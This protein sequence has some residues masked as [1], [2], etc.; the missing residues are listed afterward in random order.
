MKR[1][2]QPAWMPRMFYRP[3]IRISRVRQSFDLRLD[4]DA[5]MFANGVMKA[6]IPTASVRACISIPVA[7]FW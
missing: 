5:E 6:I 2:A 3:H 7:G 4:P 1:G